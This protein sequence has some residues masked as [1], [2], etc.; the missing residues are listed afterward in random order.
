MKKYLFND[1]LRFNESYKSI[2]NFLDIKA[3]LHGPG[4][5]T[6]DLKKILNKKFGF[7]NI[8][9]TNSCTSAMEM[10]ALAINLKFKDEVVIPSYTFAT[11]GSSFARTGCK[12]KYCDI[13][14]KN[15]MPTYNQILDCINKNTKAIVIVHYQGFSVDYL[16]KLKIFCKKNKIYLIEDAA[17]AFGSFFKNK[18]LG[19]FG[20]FG[21]F[22]FHHT[23]NIH[24]GV[25]GLL[26]LN[27]KKLKKKIDFIFDKGTDRS[28][29]I[30]NKRKYYS[31]V[32]IGSSFLLPELNVSFLL[33]QINALQKI[34]SYRKKLY[35]RYLFNFKKWSKGQFKIISCGNQKYNFHALVI[36]LNKNNRV[37]FLNFLKKYGV[38]AFI[39]YVPLHKSPY[40]KK[41]INQKRKLENTDKLEKK[42]IR[43]PLHNHLSIKDIDF[44]SSIIESFYKKN[45]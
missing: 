41:F 19:S 29:V 32:E 6:Q 25:G 20:D 9:L 2:K 30:S 12:I 43:L 3:P 38:H 42:I 44:I 18:P 28:L 33:P 40:G 22:S 4:K 17:Q 45:K 26:V 34:I 23:K 16:D 37:D 15:L 36:V 11:T 10:A 21:C 5:H 7:N 27:N 1:P 8:Y 35:Y 13:S 39:G 31:W 24:A 14:E